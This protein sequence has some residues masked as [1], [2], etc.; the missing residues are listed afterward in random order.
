MKTNRLSMVLWLLA[1]FAQNV[2][3]MWRT[4]PMATHPVVHHGLGLE[5]HERIISF[6]YLGTIDCASRR[7][8]DPPVAE[9]FQDW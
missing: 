2:G 8:S 4:G 5:S 3:A 1:A 6:L 9:Y 7:L